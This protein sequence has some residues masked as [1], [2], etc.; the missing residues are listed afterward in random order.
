[1]KEKRRKYY[2]LGCDIVQFRVSLLTFRGTHCLHLQGQRVSQ[3]G[4]KFLSSGRSMDVRPCFLFLS[5]SLSRPPTPDT[6]IFLMVYLS[7]S[8]L[9]DSV[10]ISTMAA[11]FHILSYSLF[12]NHSTNPQNVLPQGGTPH[13]YR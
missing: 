1:M 9:R 3:A 10:S 6:Q 2:V 4:S 7:T 12:T 5:R 8:R 13:S 11:S